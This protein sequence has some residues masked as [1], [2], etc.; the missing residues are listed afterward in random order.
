MFN[1]TV[2]TDYDNIVN[3]YRISDIY[4]LKTR[5]RSFELNGLEAFISKIP[6]IAT[7]GG[8][9]QEYFPNA[10]KDLLVDSCGNPTVLPGN[11]IHIGKGVEI[12]VDKAVDKTLEVMDNYDE[13]KAKIEENY[14][15]WI[16]NFSY[17]AV[18]KQLFKALDST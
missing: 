12:C 13:Y 5:G 10:L 6:T 8:A 1:L 3:I 16:E 4:L 18:K 2:N 14:N 11:P 17:E 7:K 15:F 9:W